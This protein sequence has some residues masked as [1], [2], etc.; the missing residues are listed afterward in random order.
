M[1]TGFLGL[2]QEFASANSVLNRTPERPFCLGVLSHDVCGER[3]QRMR[4]KGAHRSPSKE[5]P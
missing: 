2:Q 3:R 5:R 4:G 1:T